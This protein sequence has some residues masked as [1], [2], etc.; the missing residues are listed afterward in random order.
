MPNIAP[1]VPGYALS[2]T[3][4]SAGSGRDVEGDLAGRTR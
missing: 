4:P 1:C 2:R 3:G